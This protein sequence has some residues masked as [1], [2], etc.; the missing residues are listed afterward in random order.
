M[1]EKDE[2]SN[3]SKSKK[4]LIVIGIWILCILVIFIIFA[5]KLDSIK[6]NLKS[7]HFF[8]R[9]FGTTPTFIAEY[10][11]KEEKPADS[12][13]VVINLRQGDDSDSSSPKIDLNSL[14]QNTESSSE[15]ASDSSRTSSQTELSAAQNELLNEAANSENSPTQ[16]N[17]FAASENSEIAASEVK[18]PENA[19]ATSRSV[20]QTITEQPVPSTEIVK[21]TSAKLCFAEIDSDGVISRRE[22]SRKVVKTPSPLTN[23]I[24]LLL[25]GPNS[26]EE[27]NGCTTL[28]PE[29]TRLISASIKDGIAYLNFNKNFE[30]NR[31]GVEGYQTQLMQVVYTATEFSTVSSVQFLVEGEQKQYLG[32]EGIW[33]GT[34]LSR[35][36]FK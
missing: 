31:F 1:K 25:Q 22:I 29:E 30:F 24:K 6:S 10:K 20:T 18:I 11:E 7:T 32:S 17:E 14:M 16:Q 13:D 4:A 35:A 9:I 15:E 5:L 28:I 36:S 27:N 19:I 2:K 33:I 8:E 21:M 3:S 26:D 23:N 34:P 12:G